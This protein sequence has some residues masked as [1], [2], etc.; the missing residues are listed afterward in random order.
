MMA[1][2]PMH[3]RRARIG[4]AHEGVPLRLE[5]IILKMFEKL[6]RADHHISL[7]RQLLNLGDVEVVIIG[8]DLDA[9]ALRASFLAC[10]A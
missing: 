4:K 9:E 1:V 5:W 2:R 7:R 8:R 6:N 10:V 3:N